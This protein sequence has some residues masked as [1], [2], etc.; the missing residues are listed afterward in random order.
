MAALLLGDHTLQREYLASPSVHHRMGIVE[1]A[2][3]SLVSA[4]HQVGDA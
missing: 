1:S 3:L 2:M 4:G